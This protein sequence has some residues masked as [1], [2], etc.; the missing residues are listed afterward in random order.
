MRLSEIRY[1]TGKSYI[2]LS[3]TLGLAY[4]LIFRK[5]Y[6]YRRDKV[7]VRTPVIIAANHPTA[8]VD[9]ILFCSF[10][11]P[12]VYNMTRGDIFE[13]PIFRK[14]LMDFNMFPV[15]R[16]RDGYE[17]R[18]RNDEVFDFCRKKLKNNQLVCIFVEGEHHL[19]RR[20]LPLQKG[21]A[22]IAFGTY[23]AEQLENLQILPVGCNYDHGERTRD[24]AKI[25]VGEP[26][27]VKDYWSTYQESNGKAVT[28]L[29]KDV[30]AALREVCLHVEDKADD[31]LVE[32]LLTL[33]RTDHAGRIFPVL[34]DEDR[35]FFV[36]KALVE[37]INALPTEQKDALKAQTDLYFKGLTGEGITDA[38]LRHP[39]HGD[40]KWLW[41]FLLMLVPAA[42][43]GVLSWPIRRLAR[44][45]AAKAVKKK[46]FYTSVLLG[47]GDL[48]GLMYAFVLAV[49]GLVWG[50]YWLT[51]LALTLPIWTWMFLTYRDLWQRWRAA[52]RALD[53][54]RAGALL[55]ERQQIVAL[56]TPTPSS[57]AL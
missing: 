55:N 51:G 12:P 37:H 33:R 41:F 30:H 8:F 24:V 16:R 19:D 2:F 21:F 32:Q 38:A 34:E 44:W 4:R 22:R 1:S 56:A 35:N 49:T 57:P 28:A 20:V 53:C 29:C 5:I 52:R 45:V 27:F 42:V 39:E 23:E 6:M 25:I 10:F 9:P 47:I 50:Q 11:A 18:E 40:G 26:I 3:W 14:I 7:P 48:S 36:E 31:I 15:F 17:S 43:G 13:K 54:P 46:E